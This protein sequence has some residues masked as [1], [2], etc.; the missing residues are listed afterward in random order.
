MT[1]AYILIITVSRKNTSC[2]EIQPTYIL[3]PPCY[4]D[5]SVNNIPRLEKKRLMS[6]TN[7]SL[8]LFNKT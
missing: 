4:G 2:I 1:S 8:I 3:S 5:F 6:T 7:Y